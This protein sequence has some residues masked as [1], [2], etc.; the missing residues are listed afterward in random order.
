MKGVNLTNEMPSKEELR[1]MIAHYEDKEYRSLL[2][3]FLKMNLGFLKEV[4]DEIE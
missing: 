1:Q 3:K 2:K 4:Q